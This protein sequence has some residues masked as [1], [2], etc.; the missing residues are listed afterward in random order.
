MSG[1][2]FRGP[3]DVCTSSFTSLLGRDEWNGYSFGEVLRGG[4]GMAHCNLAGEYC[5]GLLCEDT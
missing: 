1:V 4:A 2:F 5:G 3:F